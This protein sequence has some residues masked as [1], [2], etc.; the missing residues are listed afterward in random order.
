MNLT[1]AILAAVVG[2]LPAHAAAH[3]ER[4]IVGRVEIA[5]PAR[6]MLVVRDTERD[7]QRRLEVNPETEIL[8]CRRAPDL[9]VLR[10]GASVRAMYL[11][12][13][14]ALPE[15]QSILLLH[16]GK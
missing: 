12:R 11:D 9:G 7:E 3:E 16:Q 2:L 6:K 4:L 14:G 5:Q 15:A 8:V 10:P 13:A 1:L